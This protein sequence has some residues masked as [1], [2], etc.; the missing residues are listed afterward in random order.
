MNN[1]YK[2]ITGFTLFIILVLPVSA[3]AATKPGSFF[4]FFDTAFERVNLFFTFN[5]EKKAMKA[6]DYADKRLAEVKTITEE[7]GN[8]DDIKTSI[9]NYERNIA[10]AAEKSKEVKDKGQEENLLN[11]ITNSASKN[12]EVLSAVLIKVPEEAKAAIAQAIEASKRGQEEAMKQIAELKKEVAGLKQEITELKKQQKII[13]TPSSNNQDQSTIRELKNEIEEL[14]K[15]TESKKDTEKQPVATPTTPT[16][17]VSSVPELKPEVKAND[18]ILTLTNAIG[19]S[20]T[21][22]TR[23]NNNQ[24]IQGLIDVGFFVTQGKLP[25]GIKIKPTSETP[26]TPAIPAVPVTPLAPSIPAT[27]PATPAIPATPTPTP[28]PTSQTKTIEISS[29]SAYPTLNSVRIEWQTN[30]LTNGKVFLSGKVYGSE[31]GISTRHIVN[32]SGLSVGIDYSYEIESIAG[33]QVVKKEG[34]FSTKKG[35][36]AIQADKVSIQFTNGHSIGSIKVTAQYTENGRV[37]LPVDISFSTPDVSKTYRI[38]ELSV[39]PCSGGNPFHIQLI[40]STGGS[41]VADAKVA[42]SYEPKSLGT[43]TVSVTVK[44]ITK[45][46]NIQVTEY[47]IVDPQIEKIALYQQDASG[48]DRPVETPIFDLGNHYGIVG[49]FKILPEVDYN[50]GFTDKYYESNVPNAEYL[51]SLTPHGNGGEFKV[52]AQFIDDLNRKVYK[53]PT[54]T[55]TITLKSLRVIDIAGKYRDVSGLPIIFTFKVVGQYP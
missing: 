12:Q 10:L 4:Y 34:S 55:Y 31:S 17:P 52:I 11:L 39:P 37:V 8:A 33:D 21:F 26:A 53:L 36:L 6:L 23:T 29:V 15:Q 28:T 1:L 30:I 24:K 9:A 43:H 7:G 3:S 5:P 19:I 16:A 18:H 49:R 38:T 51:L 47:V 40:G 27:T 13:P 41:C 45:S 2:I 44:G 46:V 42:F 50:P 22:D 20:Y 32:I 35:E 54:G 14:K 48:V 25:E